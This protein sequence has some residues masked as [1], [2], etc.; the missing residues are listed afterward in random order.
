MLLVP[1][2]PEVSERGSR[3]TP[4]GSAWRRHDPGGPAHR[5]R[6]ARSRAHR[7]RA[8]RLLR[9][10]CSRSRPS[11]CTRRSAL[12]DAWEPRATTPRSTSS[13]PRSRTAPTDRSAKGCGAS[14]GPAASRSRVGPTARRPTSRSTTGSTCS[15][16]TAPPSSR[17]SRCSGS[18]PA[19][20]TIPRRSP[21]WR[22]C[23]AC[24]RPATS[25][26]PA[27]GFFEYDRGHLSRDADRMAVRLADAMYRGRDARLARQRRPTRARRDRP[28]RHRLVRARRPSA[29]RG[30]RRARHPAAVGRAI[31]AGSKTAWEPGGISPFQFAHGHDVAHAEGR[32]YDSYGAEPA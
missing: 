32:A 11:T 4:R 2:P 7:L 21:C 26:A 9:L 3:G 15:P 24:S 14:T 16:T 19:P 8:Q 17:R 13:G 5:E 23:S 29:R 27:K 22:W 25:T 18:S 28:A 12:S 30:A 1:I 10:S 31:E 6:V 20:T